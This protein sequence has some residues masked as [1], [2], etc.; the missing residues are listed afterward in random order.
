MSQAQVPDFTITSTDGETYS[1]H[2]ELD[3]GK[4]IV[5]DFFS[6]TC[7]TCQSGVPQ[8]EKIWNNAL[9]NGDKGW[10]WAV[11]IMYHDESEIDA[12][13]DQYGG[14]FPAFSVIDDDSIINPDYGFD[15]PYAPQYFVICPDYTYNNVPITAI[16]QFI[17][18]CGVISNIRET[19]M[20]N[21]ILQNRSKSIF[22]DNLPTDNGQYQIQMVNMIGKIVS[23]KVVSGSASTWQ[24]SE[25]EEGIYVVRIINDGRTRFAEKILIR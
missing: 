16:S 6:T 22:I 5:I 4:V 7:G 20:D 21:I 8:M 24:S 14:S 11:E 2:N 17:E 25:L 15:V 18:K 9:E 23:N 3:K 12:F 13:F 10:V 1:I 19:A